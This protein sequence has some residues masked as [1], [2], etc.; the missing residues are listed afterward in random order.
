MIERAVR[1]L[2]RVVFVVW[3]AATCAFFIE[4]V[5][6]ADPARII[7]GVQARPEAV[8]RVRQE[9]GLDRPVPQRYAR[10]LGVLVHRAGSAR[11]HGSCATFGPV[12]VDLGTSYQE[13]RPVV[14]MLGERVPRTLVLALAGLVAQLVLGVALGLGAAR[15]APSWLERLVLRVGVL[16][17]CVPTYLLGLL[18]QYVLAHRLH[19]LPLDGY[20]TTLA[21]QAR[22][23]VLPTLTL[24]IYGAAYYARFVHDEVTTA[25]ATDYVRTARA[26]GMSRSR[27]MVAHALKPAMLPLVTLAALDLG[28]LVGGAVVT[29]S[30]F[31]WPGMGALSL[32]ALLDRDGPV[33]LGCVLVSATGVAIANAAADALYSS[34]DPRVR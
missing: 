3:A 6:P 20:G 24:G 28:T 27:A 15:A 10:F 7:A 8:A 31:R 34:L 23:L 11:T 29:E 18:L 2:L 19:W 5:L 33:V 26:K 14:K 13:N 21:E 32:A 16:T 1:R 30:L 25:L 4:C 9:L 12:H 17:T 22:C